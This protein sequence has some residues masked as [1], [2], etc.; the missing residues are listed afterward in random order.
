MRG[1]HE[2]PAAGTET[3]QEVPQLA[4]GHGVHAGRGLVQQD[5]GRVPGQRYPSAQLALVAVAA[6][7]HV[8]MRGLVLRGLK[9]TSCHRL[10]ELKKERKKGGGKKW[11]EEGGVAVNISSF[12]LLLYFVNHHHH[13]RH[14][15]LFPALL[16]PLC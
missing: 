15:H 13:H 16:A 12:F 2:G 8:D 10:G 11:G 7:A 14:H 3:G 5:E 4:P 9:G 1:E 6:Y